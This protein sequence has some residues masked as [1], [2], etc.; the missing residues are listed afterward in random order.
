FD[1]KAF[2]QLSAGV[3]H[4]QAET[5]HSPLTIDSDEDTQDAPE[6]FGHCGSDEYIEGSLDGADFNVPPGQHKCP[7]CLRTYISPV[8]LEKHKCP[9]KP[10]KSSIQRCLWYVTVDTRSPERKGAALE[11]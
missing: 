3:V 11:G 5:H 7:V 1:P 10:E 9:G 8:L 6:N 4:P 2:S